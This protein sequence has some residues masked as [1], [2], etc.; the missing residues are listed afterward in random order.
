M[1]HITTIDLLFGGEPEIVASFLV[2]V[3]QGGFVLIET[4]PESTLDTLEAGVVASGHELAEL[5]AV[6][7]THIHLDHGGAAGALAR[8]TGCPVFVHP[9]GASHLIDP[10]RLLASARRVWGEVMDT[11]WGGMMAIP[12]AQV[13]SVEDGA[14][15]RVGGESLRAWHTPGHAVHHLAWQV[16]D[17]VATGDSAGVRFPRCNHVL[18]PMPPPD[19]DIE[20]W[21]QS[22][23]R[24][25]H[26]QPARLLLTHFGHFEDTKL[27]LD[28]LEQ[29]MQRW[30]A[31]AEEVVAAGDGPDALTARLLELDDREMH[32]AG[33]AKGAVSHYRNLCPM[34]GNAAGLY[35]YCRLR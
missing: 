31:V 16:G 17:A 24:L 22:V 13:R 26:L 19:I 18:P 33:L 29:R 21:R 10:S 27:H 1:D 28:E 25:R 2:P 34:S 30:L 11:L 14:S 15:I 20:A 12:E 35:R 32:V 5:R 9:A 6:L 8:R 23:N 3:P 4:G 7:L